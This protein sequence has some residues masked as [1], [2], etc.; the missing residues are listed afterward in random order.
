[1]DVRFSCTD[2]YTFFVQG[3]NSIKTDLPHDDAENRSEGLFTPLSGGGG[4]PNEI[5]M[6]GLTAG[7]IITHIAALL[8]QEQGV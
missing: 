3:S 6:R 4:I 8:R 5:G 7:S 1:M 2:L